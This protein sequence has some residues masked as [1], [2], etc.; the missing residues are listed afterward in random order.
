MVEPAL[1]TAALA[2][3]A[4]VTR[5]W[6]S[7]GDPRRVGAGARAGDGALRRCRR[8]QAHLSTLAQPLDTP[9]F[10][11]VE[12]G[13]DGPGRIALPLR[14]LPSAPSLVYRHGQESPSGDPRPRPRRTLDCRRAA[15]TG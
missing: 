7:R 9:T 13:G 6:R 5:S 8:Y 2:H 14:L 1:A 15:A 10:V 3:A 4:S 11:D 12:R